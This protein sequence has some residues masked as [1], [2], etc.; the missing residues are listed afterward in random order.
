[1]KKLLMIVL[2][3][4]LCVSVFALTACGGVGLAGYSNKVDLDEISEMLLDAV[5]EYGYDDSDTFE[6]S[7]T[8]ESYSKSV[9]VSK[10]EYDSG[11]ITE[12]TT[13]EIS[14]EEKK[15]D[16]V[17]EVATTLSKHSEEYTYA[18]GKSSS[19]SESKSWYQQDGNDVAYS[20]NPLTKMYREY[21]D[22][23]ILDHV[24]SASIYN[25][26]YNQIDDILSDAYYVDEDEDFEFYV[27]GDVFTVVMVDE[28]EYDGYERVTEST[29]QLVF[30]DNKAE[31]KGIQVTT[32][33]NEYDDY[34]VTTTR[35]IEA[36][37]TLNFTNVTLAKEDLSK[38]N[39]YE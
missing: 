31:I 17:N 27:D 16:S 18:T 39:K 24:S 11:V 6:Q 28:Y 5:E 2:C 3:V 34:T 37:M 32:T 35:T 7:Y 14:T 13:T 25:N 19:S 29:Y 33:T 12:R 10:T 23:E 1:M 38:Y 15:Y 21:E 8:Y 4:A 22:D 30:S 26:I 36:R 20:S 9:E